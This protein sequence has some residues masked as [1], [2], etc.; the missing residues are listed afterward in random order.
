[1]DNGDLEQRVE[2]TLNNVTR[3]GLEIILNCSEE[4]YKQGFKNGLITYEKIDDVRVR[5]EKLLAK[6]LLEYIAMWGVNKMPKSSKEDLGQCVES[7][8]ISIDQVAIAQVRYARKYLTED[9]LKVDDAQVRYEELL[10]RNVL[11]HIKDY[12]VEEVHYVCRNSLNK[13]L[14][15]IFYKK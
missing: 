10:A 15:D 3:Y 5:Y 9:D 13:A 11:E 7:G 8:S 6:D 14:N 1:M 2:W 12:G 4:D